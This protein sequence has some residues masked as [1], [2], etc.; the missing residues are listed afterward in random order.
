MAWPVR[1][2]N[3]RASRQSAYERARAQ[4]IKHHVHLQPCRDEN[5][6]RVPT[7]AVDLFGASPRARFCPFEIPQ[8]QRGL[9]LDEAIFGVTGC[10]TRPCSPARM[11]HR[12]QILSAQPPLIRLLTL[13][14][15]PPSVCPQMRFRSGQRHRRQRRDNRGAQPLS[16]PGMALVAIVPLVPRNMNL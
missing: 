7:S 15:R 8:N 13:P 3:E 5:H 4:A 1:P 10:A 12:D 16:N 11:C 14:W 2:V 9:E 6:D